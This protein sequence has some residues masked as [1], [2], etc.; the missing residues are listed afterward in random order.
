MTKY[1][2]IYETFVEAE[3]LW[4]ALPKCKKYED[5]ELIGIGG[6]RF[7]MEEVFANEWKI[8]SRQRRKRG[9]TSILR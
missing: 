5:L 7:R 2:V 4:K 1:R 9:L 6:E 8:H 3:D